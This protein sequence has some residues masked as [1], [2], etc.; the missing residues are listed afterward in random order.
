MG[1]GNKGNERALESKLKGLGGKNKLVKEKLK[2]ENDHGDFRYHTCCTFSLDNN[3]GILML[4]EII[5]IDRKAFQV[6]YH[7]HICGMNK[8]PCSNQAITSC[9]MART[10]SF[11][12]GRFDGNS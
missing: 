7:C 3:S 11:I 6:Q 4:I 5:L 9:E 1:K 12:Y 2:R 8:H 10:L